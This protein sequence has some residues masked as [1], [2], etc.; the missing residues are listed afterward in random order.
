[1]HGCQCDQQQH[2]LVS[3]NPLNTD[4]ASFSFFEILPMGDCYFL[5]LY[6]YQVQYFINPLTIC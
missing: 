2:E 5:I 3:D 6:L 4:N 1:M